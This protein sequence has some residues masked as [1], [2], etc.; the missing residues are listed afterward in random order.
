VINV[1]FDQITLPQAIRVAIPS[2]GNIWQL[3]L[4]D[5]A[6]ISVTGLAEVMR[7][8]RVATNSER[9]PFMFFIVAACIFLLLTSVSTKIQKIIEKKY[10]RSM[11]R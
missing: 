9:E 1:I 2:L 3:T 6:L 11:V 4:K 10:N 5:T 7:V 8:S